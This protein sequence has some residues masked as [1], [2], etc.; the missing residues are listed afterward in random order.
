MNG[1]TPL[2]RVSELGAPSSV[3]AD[4]AGVAWL[5]RVAQTLPGDASSARAPRR[6]RSSRSPR[7]HRID[8]AATKWL[9]C[10]P[11]TA[12]RPSCP[13]E[14]GAG[15]DDPELRNRRRARGRGG[16]AVR[17]ARAVGLGQDDAAHDPRGARAAGVGPADA[18]RRAVR[19][20]HRARRLRAAG[21]PALQHADGAGDAQFAQEMRNGAT[22]ARRCAT[23]CSRRWA[24][25]AS[26]TSA[27]ATRRRCGGAG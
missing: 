11:G 20:A 13:H 24:S 4:T 15:Q 25:S 23:T 10:S 16:G 18:R 19:R 8:T 1:R 7:R 3:A 9:Q 12:S 6:S 21:G 5:S 14:E 2:S 22:Q 26:P 17:G 27:S